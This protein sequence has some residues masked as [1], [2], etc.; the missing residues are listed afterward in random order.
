MSAIIPSKSRTRQAREPA[1]NWQRV[2][3]LGDEYA[4]SGDIFAAELNAS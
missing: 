3:L 4:S 2:F 1:A